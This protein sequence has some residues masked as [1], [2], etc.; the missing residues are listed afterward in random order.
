M[1]KSAETSLSLYF[2]FFIYATLHLRFFRVLQFDV[3]KILIYLNGKR[4][5]NSTHKKLFKEIKDPY[6]Q[7]AFLVEKEQV[8]TESAPC[9]LLFSTCF[10]QFIIIVSVFISAN[11]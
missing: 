5:R 7:N 3:M 6:S 2:F 10:D 8:N 11:S 9:L 1:G 4:S